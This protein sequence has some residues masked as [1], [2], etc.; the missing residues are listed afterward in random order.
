MNIGV[1]SILKVGWGRLVRNLDNQKRMVPIFISNFA[2]HFGGVPLAPLLRLQVRTLMI[3]R[4]QC[5]GE[6]VK[7][8]ALRNFRA[9]LNFINLHF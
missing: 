2:K 9:V 8:K 7:V 6:T 3:Y 5:L 4:D 1:V